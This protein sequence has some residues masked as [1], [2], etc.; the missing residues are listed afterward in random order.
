MP[1]GIK[2]PLKYTSK[3]TDLIQY[4]T[5]I[6]KCC[7]CNKSPR[8]LCPIHLDSLN[9]LMVTFA[10]TN[11][12]RHHRVD[13]TLT[14]EMMCFGIKSRKG[15]RV[16]VSNPK[17]DISN[18]Q[19]TH[20]FTK[21]KEPTHVVPSS[22]FPELTT[23]I[24]EIRAKLDQLSLLVGTTNQDREYMVEYPVKGE[25]KVFPDVVPE[26]S[27]PLKRTRRTVEVFLNESFD[28]DDLEFGMTDEQRARMDEAVKQ[29]EVRAGT[30]V[31]APRDSGGGAS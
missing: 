17:T 22:S 7:I 13:Q 19:L 18:T 4:P 15:V 9:G 21:P 11:C 25:M 10:C 1:F 6:G 8:A 5:E 16:V 2:D 27:V 23:L 20:G 29:A 30:V 3:R 28:D 24:A 14:F 12:Y 31:E 26:A